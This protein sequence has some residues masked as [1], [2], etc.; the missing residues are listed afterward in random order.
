MRQRMKHFKSI[1]I[2][3]LTMVSLSAQ[4]L[5]KPT[6]WVFDTASVLGAEESARLEARLQRLRASGTAEAL[7]YIAPSLP[8]QT[9]LEDLTLRSVN[10]WGVG[11]AATDNGIAL[12]AFIR[13]RK[14]RIEVGRGLE[15]R[16]SDAAAKSII[17]EQI[18]PAFR[19]GNYAAG[20]TAAIDRIELLIRERAPA[21]TDFIT[22]RLGATRRIAGPANAPRVTRRVH[23]RYPHEARKARTQGQVHLKVL[24]TSAGN[25]ADITVTKGLPN[26]LSEAATTAI[27][28]WVYQPAVDA[29]GKPVPALVDVVMMFR[30]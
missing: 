13:D 18:A 26:G 16:I 11:D 8:E 6:R 15:A 23:P 27:R 1:A 7:I 9:V 22:T 17:D 24:I 3:A 19:A 10:A 28:Q 20:L 12:F 5:P 2:L 29:Q 4:E 30:L 25:V 14:L 21:A